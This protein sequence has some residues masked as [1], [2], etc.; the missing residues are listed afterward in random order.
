MLEPEWTWPDIEANLPIDV[1]GLMTFGP[2]LLTL[3]AEQAIGMIPRTLRQ[4]VTNDLRRRGLVVGIS[5]GIDSALCAALS[6]R[7]MGSD[8]VLGL[9]MPE[10]GSTGNSLRLGRVVAESLGIQTITEDISLA[11]DAL[12]C[13][14]RQECAIKEL[15]PDFNSEWKFKLVLPTALKSG[16]LPIT[17]LVVQAPDGRREQLRLR[18]DLYRVLVAATNFKQRV[19]K[20]LEYYHGDRLQYAICGTPNRLEY[21]QGFFV[22]NGDGSADVKPIAH[23]YKSQVYQLARALGIPEE[24]IGQHPTTDTFSL[25]QTQE[26][27]YFGMPYK[28]MDL[29]LYGLNH[30]VAPAEVA[31]HAGLTKSQVEFVYE[32]IRAKRRATRYLHLGAQLVEPVQVML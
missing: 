21:D 12:G 17:S 31:V 2:H 26:E 7:A 19:R 27:F 4:I 3:D 32:D 1:R 16:R 5:G 22:K 20:M 6:V 25:E 23:L 18:A 9:L 15:V 10:K 30:G 13:Y 14:R 11:L 29:C 24:I 28:S 8:R